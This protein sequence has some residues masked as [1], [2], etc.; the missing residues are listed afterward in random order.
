MLDAHMK[1]EP[2]QYNGKIYGYYLITETTIYT[3]DT[4]RIRCHKKLQN[5]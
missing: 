3:E 1:A 5:S 2:S 4:I